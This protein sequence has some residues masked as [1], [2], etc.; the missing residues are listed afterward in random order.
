VSA[1]EVWATLLLT[2]IEGSTSM[3]EA[4]PG[5]MA[6]A[7]ARHEE[8]AGE[9][10]AAHGGR[11][12]KARGEGDALFCVFESPERATEGAI[13]LQCAL[14]SEPWPTKSPISVRV[15]VHVGSVEGRD[16]DYFGPTVNRCAR[17][18]GVCH[19]GQII[20]SNAVH[21]CCREAFPWIDHGK[22][23]LKDLLDAERVFEVKW[24]E[25]QFPPLRSLN[26]FDH[27]LPVQLTSFVGREAELEALLHAVLDARLVTLTGSGGTGKSRLALQVAAHMV[28][29]SVECVR[30]VPL[31]D[32]PPGADVAAALAKGAG[33]PTANTDD[34][35]AA[36][37]STLGDREILLVIDNCEHVLDSAAACVARL[38]REC[39]SLRVL[40]TSRQNLGLSGEKIVALAPLALPIAGES[41]PVA[42]ARSESVALLLDR[43]RLK[44]GRIALDAA[45]TPLV[46]DLV[47]ALE[48]IPLAIEQVAARIAM[49]GL[50]TVTER[51][52][53]RLDLLSSADRDVEPRQ[54]TVRAT[55]A[56]SHDL[57]D[58][59]EKDVFAHLSTFRG[60]FLLSEASQLV[61]RDVV[62][63]IESL[64]HKSLL[65]TVELSSHERG[66]RMLETVRD[67]GRERIA[68]DAPGAYA[69]HTAWSLSVADRINDQL[70]GETQAAA[71]SELD[72]VYGDLMEGVSRTVAARSP[73]ALPLA[74]AM[75]RAWLLHG[76][77]TD[78]VTWLDAAVMEAPTDDKRLVA[79]SHNALGAM[80]NAC[81]RREKA[82][83]HLEIARESFGRLGD[84]AKVAAC[85]VNLGITDAMGGDYRAARDAFEAGID[86][87]RK[88]T[89]DRGL[90]SAHLNFARMLLDSGA[91]EDA[92][93]HYDFAL[94]YY[95]GQ[96]PLMETTILVGLAEI[97]AEGVPERALDFVERSLSVLQSA[98]DPSKLGMA[99]LQLA[100]LLSRAGMEQD[101][102]FF[103]TV[104]KLTTERFGADWSVHA[105][106]LIRQLEAEF[107]V[108]IAAEVAEATRARASAASEGQAIDEGLDAIA[109][110]R[111]TGKLDKTL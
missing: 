18:R 79:D 37:S 8:I 76:P 93:A 95:E 59:N 67:Y 48:G 24:S 72:R 44:G 58:D 27:N 2:D 34:V 110:V 56:W 46:V 1:N 103:A 71:L 92:A 94:R 61:G 77:I 49:L 74:F 45:S 101:A 6:K 14:A 23:R 3:W 86:S 63:E 80:A 53:R 43:V 109:R 42:A 5:P 84:H 32:Q 102:L 11:I 51:L 29:T 15:A 31:A 22:H 104:A 38:I 97:Y 82:R 54:R 100:R 17:L 57:L 78:G 105:S 81:G 90:A 106:E 28:G 7:V 9:V 89:D 111:S 66:Y 39:P 25:R 26:A 35:V 99:L 64:A 30:Y 108:Q 20:V 73:L 21:A 12:L 16:G 55:I 52:G 96:D 91:P 47:R 69:Q 10:V 83:H 75:R 98:H 88:T 87:Y 4:E 19:G 50:D 36:M 85:L 40:A 68:T 60:A 70:I 62:A 65:S 33:V 13:A 107:A 41:H